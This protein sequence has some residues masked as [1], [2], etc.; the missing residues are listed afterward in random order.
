VTAGGHQRFGREQKGYRWREDMS[1][2]SIGVNEQEGRSIAPLLASAE[3]ELTAFFSAVHRLFGAEQA[4]KAAE[5]WIE[6][7]EETDWSSEASVINW[8]GVTIVAAARF[9][10]RDKGQM[11][12]N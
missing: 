12:R 8:R 2:Q 5:N 7:L 1:N 4:R 11:S 3:K 6:V 10:G 9:V